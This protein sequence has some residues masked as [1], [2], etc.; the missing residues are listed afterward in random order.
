MTD[1]GQMTNTDSIMKLRTRLEKLVFEKI[2]INPN[3]FTH[4]KK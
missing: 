4:K 2:A 3:Q 1:R